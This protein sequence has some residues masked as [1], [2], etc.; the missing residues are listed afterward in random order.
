MSYFILNQV[1]INEKRN[2]VFIRGD[3]SN[4]SPRDNCK[5]EMK[6]ET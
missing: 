5:T 6:G 2:E 1:T 4:V 3:Y